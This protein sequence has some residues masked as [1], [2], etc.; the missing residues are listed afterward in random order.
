[1]NAVATNEGLGQTKEVIIALVVFSFGALILL[2]K[3]SS[4]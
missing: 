4:H 2:K 1:M 3:K